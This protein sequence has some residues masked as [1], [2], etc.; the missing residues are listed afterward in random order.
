MK[1]KNKIITSIIILL[2]LWIS[3]AFA[4]YW[5]Y[6]WTNKTYAKTIFWYDLMI[7]QPYNFNLFKDYKG[8]KICYI[9][10]WEFDGTKEE[11]DNLWL[12]SAMKWY[13]SER[14]S[15]FMDMS[16][17]VW[18]NYLLK[19]EAELKNMKCSWIFLDTIWQEWQKKWWIAIVKKL[20]ENWKDAYI[21]VNN[22]H[23]IKNE[24][25][26]YVDA[27]MFENFWDKTVKLWSE[28]AKWLDALSVEYQALAKKY[29][30]RIFAL[31]YWV[32]W[33]SKWWTSIKT[34]AKKY[35]FELIFTNNIINKMYN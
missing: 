7:L 25:V 6:Y 11:M 19:K 9:T 22:W 17:T 16:S 13:N 15:Y 1:T 33:T 26:N 24:I 20:K 21:V 29:N 31:S 27:Y 30:K 23:E 32:P 5:I 3:S 12:T 14:N 8:K 18:Q 28:D 34:K 2:S 10:V 4:S 35:W